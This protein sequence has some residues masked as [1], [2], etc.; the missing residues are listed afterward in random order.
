M[1]VDKLQKE[2]QFYKNKYEHT[3]K[4]Y[5]KCIDIIQINNEYV[6]S[7]ISDYDNSIKLLTEENQHLIDQ[8]KELYLKLRV[9]NQQRDITEQAEKESN[10]YFEEM[11]K[12]LI[13]AYQRYQ[14][15][16]S[17]YEQSYMR[18]TELR[19]QFNDLGITL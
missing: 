6:E 9:C 19:K 2:L 7:L 11:K 10:A 13:S 8:K 4:E 1:E 18:I 3:R 16:N 17:K 12:R 5:K 14:Q 15:M